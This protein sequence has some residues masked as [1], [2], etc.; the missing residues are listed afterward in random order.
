MWEPDKSACKLAGYMQ[1]QNIGGLGAKYKI[2][3]GAAYDWQPPF[4]DTPRAIAIP[5]RFPVH[6]NKA[7]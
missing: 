4:A 2:I 1:V 3:G 6:I 5:L 7:K